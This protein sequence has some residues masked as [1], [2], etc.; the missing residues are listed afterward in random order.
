MKRCHDFLKQLSLNLEKLFV[1]VFSKG[2][3]HSGMQCTYQP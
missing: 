2:Y 1:V 3:T